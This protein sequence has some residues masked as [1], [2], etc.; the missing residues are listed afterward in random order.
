M[1]GM[2]EGT[3]RPLWQKVFVG[4]LLGLTLGLSFGG[5]L[6]ASFDFSGP[7]D[8]AS[9]ED[10]RAFFFTSAFPT[11]GRLFINLIMMIVV[12]LVF[13][14]LIAGI[15][16]VS[17]PETLGRVGKKAMGLYLATV[18]GAV[19]LGIACGE[20]MNPGAGFDFERASQAAQANF[21][22]ATN[23][24]GAEDRT[25]GQV[26]FDIVPTNGL[27]AMAEGRMIQVVFFAIFIGVTLAAMREKGRRVVELC[28]DIAQVCFKMIGGIIKLSPYAVFFL[29]AWVASTLGIS[30]LEA[31]SYLVL[32]VMVAMALQYIVYALFIAG[33]ARISPLPFMKKSFEYQSIAFSTSSSKATLATTIE[34]VE[35]RMGV[36]QASSRFVLPLGAAVNMDGTAIYLA[37]IAIFISQATGVHLDFHHYLLLI[38]TATIGSIGAAG[39]PGGSLVMMPLVLASAGLGAYAP[40]MIAII[41]PIDRVLDMVRTTINITGDACVTLIVDKWEKHLDLERYNAKI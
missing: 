36:S 16:G 5:N 2:E 6:P 19:I 15:N 24:H 27:S 33:L 12:P 40:A 21:T 10:W 32:T 7:F 30:V 37:I 9:Y 14:S 23:G 34:V 20:L 1:A 22:P 17:D 13:F 25:I 11:L 31:L 38:V 4:L 8:V 29:M 18:V 28:Q 26:L 41:T 39:Y 35:N 3:G